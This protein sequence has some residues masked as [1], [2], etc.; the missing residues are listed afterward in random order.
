MIRI[1][2]VAASMFFHFVDSQ[3]NPHPLAHSN[4]AGVVAAVQI[5]RLFSS[6][7]V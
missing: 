5:Q 2:I 3:D 6:L 1:P 7:I 4:S